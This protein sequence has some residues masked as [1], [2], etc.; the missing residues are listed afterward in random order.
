[1][2]N[3]L[4]RKAFIALVAACLINVSTMGLPILL[5]VTVRYHDYGENLL[6]LAVA[7]S[8]ASVTLIWL[9]AGKTSTKESYLVAFTASLIIVL[10]IA[11]AAIV[12]LFMYAGI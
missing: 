6:L 5:P 12:T 2:I 10:L 7:V 9:R 1:M 11:G 8:L 3:S 4:D